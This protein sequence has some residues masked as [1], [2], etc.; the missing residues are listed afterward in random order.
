M[1]THTDRSRL[2]ISASAKPGA[3]HSSPH[4]GPTRK[5]WQI[6]KTVALMS[7]ARSGAAASP[8]RCDR[9]SARFLCKI[10]R[11]TNSSITGAHT[12]IHK[13]CCGLASLT[14]CKPRFRASQDTGKASASMS[15]VTPEK[16][17][18]FP[19]GGP[20]FRVAASSMINQ[21]LSSSCA[22][23]PDRSWQPA[24]RQ[25]SQRLPVRSTRYNHPPYLM[26]KRRRVR[27]LQD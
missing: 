17:N 6:A 21:S 25:A 12:S 22:A 20:C 27:L 13:A 9:K 3:T 5:P 18:T 10:L 2:H 15:K 16:R 14:G 24:T 8:T 1:Q 19:P 4:R 7:T 11:K 23:R 26:R